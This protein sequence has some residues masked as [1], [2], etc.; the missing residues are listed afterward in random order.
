MF[1]RFKPKYRNGQLVFNR[2]AKHNECGFLQPM[3]QL[4]VSCILS[5]KPSA[6][7][8]TKYS[9]LCTVEDQVFDIPESD[10]I[11]ESELTMNGI[12][13][14]RVSDVCV[15]LAK[16]IGILLAIGLIIYVSVATQVSIS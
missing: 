4:S 16:C 15:F 10:L 1:I 2:F 5:R 7:S 3:S 11:S 13:A 9:Y 8:R 14:N 6:T 12:R